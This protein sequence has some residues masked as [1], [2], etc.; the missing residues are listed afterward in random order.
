MSTNGQHHDAT[1]TST[2]TDASTVPPLKIILP[3]EGEAVGSELAVVFQTSAGMNKMSISAPVL[4]V[5]LHI[6]I[7]A[8][9][10]MPTAK[11]SIPFGRQS[12]LVRVRPASQTRRPYHPRFL[13]Q[14][15]ALDH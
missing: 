14:P 4:G 15:E 9:V 7:D 13:G 6:A 12:P 1:A 10:L 5:H 2:V 8:V 11:Q 3:K